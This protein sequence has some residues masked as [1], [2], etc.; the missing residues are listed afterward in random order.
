MAKIVIHKTTEQIFVYPIVSGRYESWA[1]LVNTSFDDDDEMTACIING[2][3]PL[4]LH[5]SASI[6]TA[7]HS[8]NPQVVPGWRH[9]SGGIN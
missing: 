8:H 3:N 4:T 6:A 9:H 2:A 1:Y 5:L 7:C